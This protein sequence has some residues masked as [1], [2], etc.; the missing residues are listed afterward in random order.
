M[1]KFLK[2]G[3]ALVL[4]SSVAFQPIKAKEEVAVYLNG[5]TT[6]N[7]YDNENLSGNVLTYIN[8][9]SSY[10]GDVALLREGKKAY[11]IKVS[12][13]VGWIAKGDFETVSLDELSAPSYYTMNEKGEYV[14]RIS[15]NPYKS[16]YE[17]YVLGPAPDFFKKDVRY[18]SYDGNYFYTDYE[19]MIDDYQKGNYEDAVNEV[20]FYNY[21]LYAPLRTKSNLKKSTLEDYLHDQLGVRS[22][23]TSYPASYSQSVLYGECDAFFEVQDTYGA[24]AAVLFAVAMNESGGGKSQYAIER[25]NLF[26]LDAI[27]HD[28]DQASRFES[29]YECIE[30]FAAGQLNWG[31]LSAT[32][33]RYYGGHLGNKNSGLNVKYASDPY[34]GEKAASYYYQLDKAGGMK[35]YQSYRL[36]VHESADPYEVK[37][38][39]N[40]RAK[41]LVTLKTVEQMPYALLGEENGYYKVA[42]DYLLDEGRSILKY[43]DSLMYQEYDRDLNYVYFKKE[44]L[45]EIGTY[46]SGNER[47]NES[48]DVIEIYDGS[49]L[50]ELNQN[51]SASRNPDQLITKQ[52]ALALKKLNIDAKGISSF[53]GIE[54]FENVNELVLRNVSSDVD[55]EAVHELNLVKIG[56]ESSLLE[57]FSDAAIGELTI[58]DGQLVDVSDYPLLSRLTIQGGCINPSR[59]PADLE[60]NLIDQIYQL[61][62]DE[63][64]G[65]LVAANP[66]VDQ[67][68]KAI[69]SIEGLNVE[70]SNLIFADGGEYPFTISL[71]DLTIEGKVIVEGDLSAA[72][73]LEQEGWQSVGAYT[74]YVENKALVTGWKD[75]SS[76]WYAFDANGRMLKGWQKL[77]GCWY[78]LDENSG[79]MRTGWVAS[80]SDWYWMSPSSGI[81]QDSQWIEAEG[82]RFYVQNDGTMA[83]GEVV[84]DEISYIFDERGVLLKEGS[85]EQPQQPDQPLHPDG[86]QIAETYTWS[87]ENGQYILLNSKNQKVYGWAKVDGCWFFLDET[88]GIMRTG[89]VAGGNDWYWMSPSSGVMQDNQWIEVDGAKYYVGLDAKMVK[90][91]V[92][93]DGKTYQFSENGSLIG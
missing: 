53:N 20:P 81:M 3:M 77:N 31:Y 89:W 5:G 14:H 16:S 87:S 84:I 82:Q 13:L 23:A 56:I 38:E 12:G 1:R 68:G 67:K 88:T 70:G 21:Y 8:A 33:F 60:L 93:I 19:E 47:P 36:L 64:D 92:V 57:E 41:T 48:G 50:A 78:F 22:K 29:V 28:P 44:D 72:V 66:F 4:F 26:G 11:Q 7:V 55:M 83:V 43:K 80:G 63:Q 2:I 85:L 58:L 91:S 73:N 71:K 86:E 69:T 52:E 46:H 65:R 17:A 10:G 62:V 90:G 6:I 61:S 27:D 45:Y 35:D 49:L 30:D 42:S 37:Q 18:Y 59:L 79:A 51:I 15:R 32:N 40:S 39:A 75:I 74:Y 9:S 54:A 34:W 76:V 25:N 24:N